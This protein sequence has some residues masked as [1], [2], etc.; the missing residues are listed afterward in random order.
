M[1]KKISQFEVTTSFEENDILTL[2]QNKTNKIIYK[3]D[4]ETSLSG[5][6]ATNERVDGIEE[7]IA[8]LDTKVDN[9]YTDLS[10]KI[11]EGDTNVTN[12]L[13][14][15]I[16]SYYDVLNNKIITLED[17]HDKDITEVND[18]V[19]GW[20]DT[21]DDKSTKDQ[22]QDLINRLI[23]DENII[24]SLAD[25]IANGGGS[26]TA[27]G[28]H[29]QPTS[30]IFPLSGYYK[31]TNA[32]PLSTTDTLNQ[33]LAKL[34][35]QIANISD[36]SGSLPLIKTGQTTTPSDGTI[37]TSGKVKEDYL[38]KDGDTA[39][40]YTTFLAGI[41]GGKTFRE[42][43]DGVGAS[44][45]PINGKWKLELDELFVRG[46]MT[47][48]ELTVNEIKAVGG[49]ILVTVAD[50]ECVEVE[51]AGD[52]W[53]CYFDDE[54]GTKYNEFRIR[55]QVICQKF[56]GKNVK[57][58]WRM[59]T[60]VGNNYIVLSKSVCEAGSGYPEAGDKMILL[61][62]RV[63]ADPDL[64]AQMDERRTAIFISAKGSGAPRIAFYEN[65]DD[66]TLENKDRTVIGK[67][68]KFVGTIAQTTETGDIVR[69]PV[70]RG[71]WNPN[72]TYNYYDQVTYQGSLWIAMKDNVT[73]TPS[74]D[75]DEWQLQVSKG[76]SGKPGDDVAKWV[77]ITGSRLFLYDT[78]DYSGIPN[79]SS[80]VLFCNTYGMTNPTFE[81][82]LLTEPIQV[83][84]N[85]E[86]TEIPHTMFPDR[87][88][89]V[90]CV[91]TDSDGSTYYD[92]CQVAKLANGAEGLDA[93]YVDLTNSTVNIPFDSSG[94]TPL[95][96]LNTICTEVY[97]YRGIE[98]IEIVSITPSVSGA[99]TVEVSGNRITLTS[100]NSVSVTVRLNIK[101]SDST[102]LTKDWYINKTHDGESG[103]DGIDAA[104]ALM[105]GEQI[106]KYTAGA[107]MPV[108]QSIEL[109]SNA[110]NIESPV[111]AWYWAIPGTGD[112]NLL[113]NETSAKLVVS[114]NGVYF[115]GN[116]EVTFKCEVTSV[117]GGALYMDMMTINKI[118][119]GVDGE[120]VYRGVLTNEAHTVA[121][122][123]NGSVGNDELARATSD[124][125]MWK[126]ITELQ[127]TEFSI[128][129]ELIDGSG[130]LTLDNANK[131]IS[132]SSLS[133]DTAVWRIH[134][135][136]DA[137]EVDVCDFTVTKAKGGAIGNQ[138]ISIYCMTTSTPNRPSNSLT[139]RPSSSG[140]SSNGY[141]WYLDPTYST[142]YSTWESKGTVDPNTTNG[143]VIIDSTTGYRWSTPVKISG[144]DGAQGPKGDT[145]P[146]GA[147]GANGS[148]GVDGPG[149]NYRGEW[150]SGKSYGWTSTSAGNVRDVVKDGSYYYMWNTYY[151]GS[152]PT[153]TS[154]NRPSSSWT[155]TDNTSGKY[156]VRFGSSFE[157]IATG[158]LFAEKATI[159]GWD[160][161]EQYIASHS[162]TMRLDGN[163]SPLSDIHL[164][165]GNNAASS[166]GS[167]PFRVNTSGELYSSA[168]KIGGWYIGSNYLSNYSGN[169]SNGTYSD[170][171]ISMYS[172]SLPGQNFLTLSPTDSSMISVRADNKTGLSIYTQSSTGTA[173]R[174]TAQTGAL[175]LRGAGGSSWYQREGETWNMAGCL[176]V[177]YVG[178]MSSIP[179]A[180]WQWGDGAQIPAVT[181][182]SSGS[183]TVSVVTGG[184]HVYPL[185]I[186]NVSGKPVH[187]VVSNF[188]G[189]GS[190]KTF[191]LNSYALNDNE[192]VSRDPTAVYVF[193]FGRNRL[194]E[195]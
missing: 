111:Y 132:V 186:C 89:N 139:S 55:D 4:F 180:T 173:I 48:N 118:Y 151:R 10:N 71:E 51:D 182:N 62:H 156:W 179:R 147:N 37:Y 90:R 106:F 23:A 159:A 136:V 40:G 42:G 26:G 170:A 96:G 5:T 110:F 22:L 50:M 192:Y 107:T 134:F 104:Y 57:R 80:V 2:V 194:I 154:T 165:V 65:I 112:W 190:S 103:F 68:S 93:Y 52:G 153:A 100:I 67:N 184:N 18:T 74:A 175:A 25:L 126:G 9:N 66:F 172:S 150:E 6:F 39:T 11:I 161:Y 16:N 94:N 14:S 133:S 168:G 128:T 195:E 91:V 32:G 12:N 30:T 166:P 123:Y 47:V 117:N 141:T 162:N 116:D 44:L 31:G 138:Q 176:A 41:Q 95:V 7:D 73:S 59:V 33:A 167:A 76:D 164:A 185:V 1:N 83:I 60:E 144:K 54:D 135:L 45:W 87:T 19:Q 78:P 17:K 171:K 143:T 119:D 88:A 81:W 3:D 53:I 29:T 181:R 191:S 20:I 158:L 174:V 122:S 84:G 75:N 109:T 178:N 187:F 69:I 108:P 114:P 163:A 34:E 127:K 85:N 61:G 13:N 125:K 124:V 72:T 188:Q 77:E 137:T 70:Y 146:A 129:Q 152:T 28:F 27:P 58:Y 142:S 35:N 56:D 177:Y 101:L 36:N 21:I 99:A 49:D 145:G 189:S 102:T 82:R 183:Y 105:T 113:E 97:A 86:A 148:N 8:N 193:L 149:L 64:N 115:T 120:S 79:P 140:T 63:E 98:P 38:R 157:S 130:S 46:N 155:T 43:W 15:N 92:D 169:S 24:T 121:A 131:R 160:F